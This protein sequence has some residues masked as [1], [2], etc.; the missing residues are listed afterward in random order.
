[1]IRALKY[2]T[3]AVC[4][5]EAVAGFTRR[6]PTVSQLCGRRRWL[7]PVAIGGLTLHLLFPFKEEN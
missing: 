2:A 1:M 5:Y 7:I 3:F 6:C 4:G